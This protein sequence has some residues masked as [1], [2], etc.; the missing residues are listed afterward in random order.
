M[1]L[2]NNTCK[3]PEFAHYIKTGSES[4]FAKKRLWSWENFPLMA[5][6]GYAKV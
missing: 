1:R 5:Y 4:A 3:T 2:I 6:L